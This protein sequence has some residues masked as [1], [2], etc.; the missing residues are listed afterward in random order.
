M[1]AERKGFKAGYRGSG[2]LRRLPDGAQDGMKIGRLDAEWKGG[3]FRLKG[4]G[5]QQDVHRNLSHHGINQADGQ[6]GFKGQFS[7][8]PVMERLVVLVAVMLAE[9]IE[10]VRGLQLFPVLAVVIQQHGKFKPFPP[11]E[12]IKAKNKQ[13]KNGNG[14]FHEDK[15]KVCVFKRSGL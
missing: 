5:R 1:Q 9:E 4:A 2:E 11:K 7:L 12:G 3:N 6:A 13:H 15:N 10:K 8:V 14:L